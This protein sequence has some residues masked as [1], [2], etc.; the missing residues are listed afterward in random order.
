MFLR[1]EKNERDKM[2]WHSVAMSMQKEKQVVN[3]LEFKRKIVHQAENC[4]FMTKS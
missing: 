4:Q 3:S 1:W 2:F